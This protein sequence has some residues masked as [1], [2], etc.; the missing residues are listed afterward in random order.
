[1]LHKTIS[2][3][4]K[5]FVIDYNIQDEIRYVCSLISNIMWTCATMIHNF[6]SRL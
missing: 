3:A 4:G 5:F 1:M 2:N 6:T